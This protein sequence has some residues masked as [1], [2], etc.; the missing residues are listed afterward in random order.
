M[1][2]TETFTPT[3][4]RETVPELTAEQYDALLNDEEVTVSD[5]TKK[6]MIQHGYGEE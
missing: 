2:R 1:K 6:Y 3:V 4:R 5:E